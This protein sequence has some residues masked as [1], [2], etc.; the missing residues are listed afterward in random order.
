MLPGVLLRAQVGG[1]VRVFGFYN[2]EQKNKN[3]HTRLE[4]LSMCQ[5][6]KL[7]PKNQGNVEW[8]ATQGAATGP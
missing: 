2:N 8:W 4:V 1:E 6:D 7:K 3:E 5:H